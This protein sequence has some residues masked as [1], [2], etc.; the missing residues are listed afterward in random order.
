MKIFLRSTFISCLLLFVSIS[1]LVFG[2]TVDWPAYRGPTGQGVSEAKNPPVDWST[3]KNV[4]WKTKIPGRGWSSPLILDGKIVLTTGMDEAVNDMHELK[5]LQLDAETGDIIWEKT[6]LHATPEEAEDKNPK[7][8]LASPTPAIYEGVIYAHFGH[9]GTVALDFQTGETLWKQKIVYTSKNGAGGSPVV[10]DNLL[11]YTTDSFEA[12]VITALFKDTGKIAW[13]TTRSHKVK[14]N[15]SFGTPLVINNHGRK[16]IIS[17]GSGMVG[18]YRPEDGKELWLVRYPMGYSLAARPIFVDNVLYLGTGFARPSF[19]AIRVDRATGDLTDTHVLWKNHKSMPKTPSPNFV[20][21]HV[22]TLEDDGRLQ[23]LDSKTGERRWI[24]TLKGKF[25]ASPVQ[26]GNLFY[27]VSE[28]GLC[29]VIEI[30]ED[31]CE[32][33]NEIDMEEPSLSSPAIVDNTIY[34]R[35]NPHL[36]KISN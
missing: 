29:Y 15:F 11:V 33:L 12:P 7:N 28:E 10:V 16:E 31:G 14:N 1:Q 30:E 17:P 27:C 4:V 21:G 8:S 23:C 34:I 18:A 24:E 6:V 5:V 20:M 3:E 36:W 13:R 26:V 19:Y 25:S 2:G 9:M 35:T 22:I 32:I